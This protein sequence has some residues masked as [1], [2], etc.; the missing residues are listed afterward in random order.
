VLCAPEPP[1][2]PL[3]FVTWV[4]NQYAIATPQGKYGFGVIETREPQ[5]M[6]LQGLAISSAVK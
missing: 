6:E 3:G 2:G 5:W 4:D 1:R